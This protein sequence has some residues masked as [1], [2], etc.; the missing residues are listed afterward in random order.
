VV[1]LEETRK[2]VV[3]RTKVALFHRKITRLVDVGKHGVRFGIADLNGLPAL[4]F[5][6]EPTR[7][8][9]APRQV[10]R[11]ELDADGLIR[12]LHGVL[13]SNK[14]GQVGFARLRPMSLLERLTANGLRRAFTRLQAPARRLSRHIQVHPRSRARRK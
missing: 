5:E 8:D 12:E 6:Y 4:L 11:V 10:F 7:S 13:A 9:F 3:G 1:K 14:L 2:A